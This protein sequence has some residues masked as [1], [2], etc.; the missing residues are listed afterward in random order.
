M[1]EVQAK[2][3]ALSEEFSKIQQGRCFTRLELPRHCKTNVVTDLQST[4]SARQKLEAQQ[5]ENEGVKKVHSS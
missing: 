2:L 4:I 3:Q 1:A 5:A